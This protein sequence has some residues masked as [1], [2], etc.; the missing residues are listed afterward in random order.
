MKEY[1][2]KDIAIDFTPGI[3]TE[4]LIFL[5]TSKPPFSIHGL[6]YE[7]DAYC[8][9]PDAVAEAVSPFVRTL[10]KYTAGGRLRFRLKNSPHFSVHALGEPKKEHWCISPLSAMEGIDVYVNG[11]FSRIDYPHKD[12]YLFTYYAYTGDDEIE[13]NLPLSRN[14]SRIVIGVSPDAVVCEPRKYALE[15]PIVFYGSSIT[16]GMCASRPGMTYEAQ[17]SRALDF[18]YINLGFSGSAKAEDAIAD[19]IAGLDMSVFVYDYDHNAP[20]PEYLLQTHEKMFL[21]VREKHPDLP[22]LMLTRPRPSWAKVHDV[23][24]RQEVV[25]RT[26]DNAVARGDKNVYYIPGTDLIRDEIGDDWA[27]CGVHP[28]DLGFF[29]MAKSIE[30]TLKSIIERIK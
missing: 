7:N 23:A 30:P 14:I 5:D 4:D 27:V 13:I 1:A 12:E 24:A 10:S 9:I 2:A 6:M 8:R 19:Y 20:N 15:K 28:T 21:K 18:D 25:K 16:Q 29:S 22:I 11:R 3:E 17:L 26:Y